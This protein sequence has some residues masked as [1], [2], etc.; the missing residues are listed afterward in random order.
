MTPDDLEPLDPDASALRT[1]DDHARAA[2]EGLRRATAVAAPPLGG[3]PLGRDARLSA[4]DQPALA[5]AGRRPRPR[6]VILG[7][8]A[9]AVIVA[10]VGVVVTRPGT[11]HQ[12]NTPIASA[13]TAAPPTTGGPTTL[14]P[15]TAATVTITPHTGL[16]DLQ[17]VHVVANGFVPGETYTAT[18]C[19]NKGA[20][21][22]PPID[23]AASG[24]PGDNSATADATGT[25]SISFQVYGMAARVDCAT[26]PGCV[27]RVSNGYQGAIG[28]ISFASTTTHGPTTAS[29]P[30]GTVTITPNTGLADPE[31]VHVVGKGFVSGVLYTA[32]ECA[33]KG[34]AID[35]SINCVGSDQQ[36]SGSA[37]ADATG[38][39][40]MY[41]MVSTMFQCA[42]FACSP[43]P[44]PPSGGAPP[45]VTTVDCSTAPG[46]VIRVTGGNQEP[47]TGT[48]SFA[49]EPPGLN[50]VLV[51]STTTT[52]G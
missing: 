43:G 20:A 29:S 1:L 15:S 22:E 33:N 18:E 35:P 9:A 42:V 24:G 27:I 23:C 16:T 25:V 49:P 4:S 8:A 47:A 10:A 34:A 21:I 5:F 44:P 12:P 52:V 38:T 26:A 37:I 19:A 46:C 40:S 30:R 14:R 2:A 51:P 50:E 3:R 6:L 32:T 36:G 11:H 48:L 13:T 39:V 45:G 17:I 7:L 31:V 28:T 41:V